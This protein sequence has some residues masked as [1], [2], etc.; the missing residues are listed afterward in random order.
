MFPIFSDFALSLAAFAVV[1]AA[2]DIFLDRAEKVRIADYF[3]SAW[4]F[5][6]IQ[7]WIRTIEFYRTEAFF[8]FSFLYSVPIAVMVHGAILLVLTIF[9]GYIDGNL[10][11]YLSASFAIFTVYPLAAVVI[12]FVNRAVFRNKEWSRI[13]KIVYFWAVKG[14]YRTLVLAKGFCCLIVGSLAV[15]FSLTIDEF[16]SKFFL[17]VP[18]V[19]IISSLLLLPLLSGF[20]LANVLVVRV[21]ASTFLAAPIWIMERILRMVLEF[22]KG[23]ILGSAAVLASIGAFLKFLG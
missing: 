17:G 22:E 6:S 9:D 3:L 19:S 12:Y 4:Y 1:I 13:S 7:S 23:P 15:F 16:L 21:L 2:L 18:L 20:A 14:E 5:I 10:S 8:R 11:D